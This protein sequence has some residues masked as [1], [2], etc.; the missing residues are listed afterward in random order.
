MTQ[1]QRSSANHFICPLGT[2]FCNYIEI[3]S[4]VKNKTKERANKINVFRREN[5]LS[6]TTKQTERTQTNAKLKQ[7]LCNC[8]KLRKR[9]QNFSV[10][11]FHFHF[12]QFSF[13]FFFSGC[14]SQ[15]GRH[16]L[17]E[18]LRIFPFPFSASCVCC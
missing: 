4:K 13:W 10:Y 6:G 5:S 17:V 12:I 14:F 3:Q 11:H 9:L 15:A 8:R 7:F 1:F 2:H 18:K 16:C